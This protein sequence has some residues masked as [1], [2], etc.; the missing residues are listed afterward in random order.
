MGHESLLVVWLDPDDGRLSPLEQRVEELH[1]GV[2]RLL[3]GP[4]IAEVIRAK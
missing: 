2:G 1:L 4:G 3:G